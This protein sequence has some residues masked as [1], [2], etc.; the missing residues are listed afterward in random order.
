GSGKNS[1]M[2]NNINILCFDTA[3]GGITIG[4]G[5]SDGSVLTHYYETEREQASLLVPQLQEVLEKGG[6]AFQDL[7]AVACTIGPG[8]FTGLRIEMTTAKTLGLSLEKPVIGINTLDLMVRHY[9]VTDNLLILLETKRQDF[10]A[11]YYDTD[12]KELFEPFA[13]SAED[14]LEKAPF[15]DFVVG[16]DCLE[17]FKSLSDA[18]LAY[19]NNI[20]HPQADVLV[21]LA[22]EYYQNSEY[23]E[24]IEPLY[25]RGADTSKPK[26]K[27]R[28]LA[29]A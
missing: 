22:F 29:K 23:D 14:I 15:D 2:T 25:L 7:D 20:E 18:S 21:N 26:H 27:P 8:S 17:R 10:Y 11:C 1:F 19:L 12:K 9:D 24:R 6:I 3:L 4:V 13:A 16:G 28:K 5:L